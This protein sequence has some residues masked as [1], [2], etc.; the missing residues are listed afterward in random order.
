ML[1]ALT[2]AA[3]APGQVP[4]GSGSI[5]GVVLDA[6]T[7][8]PI[9]KAIINTW[10]AVPPRDRF[11]VT[12]NRPTQVTAKTEASGTFTL[13]GLPPGTYQ[14]NVNHPRYPQMPGQIPPS[15]E[16]KAGETARIA[17]SL[18]PG[19]SITGRIVDEDG[20]PLSG[21]WPQLLPAR[22]GDFVGVAGSD[23]SDSSGVYSI[24]GIAPG[25]FK[26]M[27]R[28]NTQVLEAHPLRL[29]T[30]PPPPPSLAYPPEFYPGVTDPQQAQLMEVAAGQEKTGVDFQVKPARV[31]TVTGIV[32]QGNFDMS[33]LNLMLIPRN[34]S[35]RET[36]GIFGASIDFP[37]STFTFQGVFP[38]SYAIIGVTRDDGGGPPHYGLRQEVEVPG[39]GPLELELRSGADVSGKVE[40]EG[41]FK[42]P[43][44]TISV[45]LIETEPVGMGASPARIGEDGSFTMPGVLPGIYR[46]NAGGPGVFV[47]S[48]TWAGTEL[49]GEVL[50]ATAGGSGPLGI[51]LSTKA[52]T[53]IG[54]GPPN[55]QVE[56]V[57]L[58]AM[59][60]TSYAGQIDQQGNFTFTGLPPGTYRVTL[61]GNMPPDDA[62]GEEV[63][64]A[65]AETATV[66]LRAPD[67][68]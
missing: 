18:T 4:T 65:E 61:R 54:T 58:S 46:I 45:Q 8:S 50:D 51:L 17:I 11:S 12:M 52:A 24:W 7:R 23:S 2:A 57:A 20:D 48:V 26:L 43:L 22:Q 42:Y 41:E 33:K 35:S 64:L 27:I 13:H 49:S 39:N 14:I 67:G 21:C 9:R 63:T 3:V 19:G 53:I 47:K 29:T 68:R 32:R 37:K 60:R 16:V 40:V 38:G 25:R 59:N 34:Q 31:L 56:A 28:C 6:A 10:F 15:V 55:R 62:S 30:E 1:L 36:G 66:T 5:E 44:N